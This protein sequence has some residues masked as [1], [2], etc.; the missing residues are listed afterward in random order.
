MF[1]RLF[2]FLSGAVAGVAGVSW[3][4]RRASDLRD[5]VTFESSVA[6]A[7]D[8]L[9]ILWRRARVAF[10]YVA[11]L[12]KN[13]GHRQAAPAAAPAAPPAVRRHI[14]TRPHNAHG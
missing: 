8:L 5:A 7:G 11:G 12:S 2:W 3:A 1:R 4:K 10:A 6:L 13:A 14:A 9:K